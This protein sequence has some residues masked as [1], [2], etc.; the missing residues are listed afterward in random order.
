MPS[1]T[2]ESHAHGRGQQGGRAHDPVQGD[3]PEVRLG[4]ED[5]QGV[6]DDEQQEGEGGGPVAELAGAVVAPGEEGQVGGEHEEQH[7]GHPDPAG[8]GAVSPLR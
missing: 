1:S 5:A 4:C 3:A 2:M 6:A 7:L 8:H